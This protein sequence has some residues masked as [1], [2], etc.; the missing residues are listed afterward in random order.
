MHT[1]ILRPALVYGPGVKGNLA[2]MLSAVARGRM[3]PLPDSGKQRSMVALDN[4][5]DAATL[6]MENDAAH[7]RTYIVCDEQPYSTRAIY[8]SMMHCVQ[9][10]LPAVSLPLGLFKLAA[11]AGDFGNL[12]TDNAM[13]WDSS[14]YE[15]LFGPAVYS[16]GRIKQELGWRPR[17]DFAQV[18]PAMVA[19]TQRVSP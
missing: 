9:R 1:A 6:A 11:R 5:V 13:P 15:R 3:P 2:R 4:L 18:L 12:L 16:A 7:G 19:A 8:Q 14:A 17:V 10:P